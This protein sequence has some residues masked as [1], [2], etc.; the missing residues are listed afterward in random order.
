MTTTP[1]TYRLQSSGLVAAPGVV[2]WAI[3]GYAFK[4]D[5]AKL[6][7]VVTETWKGVPDDA[8]DALLSKR[9]PFTVSEE[10]HVDF[11]F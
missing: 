3:N 2:R 9:V 10:G 7:R 6:R 1:A 11:V 8:V 4:K 5:R